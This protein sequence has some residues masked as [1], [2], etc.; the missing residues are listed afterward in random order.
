MSFT[1]Q[2]MK[3]D[4]IAFINKRIS[5]DNTWI[6]NAINDQIISIR[7]C[8]QLFNM[9]VIQSHTPTIDAEKEEADEFCDQV[10]S[11][12]D[13]ICSLFLVGYWNVKAANIKKL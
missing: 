1:T 2:D 6:Y 5:K 7:F 13:R 3:T 12:I 11:K 10:Q 4:G 8:R 9:A